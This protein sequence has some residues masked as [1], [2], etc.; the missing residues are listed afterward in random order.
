MLKLS[1]SHAC[2]R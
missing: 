2:S 1:R